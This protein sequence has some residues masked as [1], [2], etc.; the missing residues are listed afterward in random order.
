[1]LKEYKGRWREWRSW[2]GKFWVGRRDEKRK[3]WLR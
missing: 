3:E 1:M 2:K